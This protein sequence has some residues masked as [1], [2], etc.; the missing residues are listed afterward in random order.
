MTGEEMV[1][2]GGVQFSSVHARI[3]QVATP[4]K[5]TTPNA[6]ALFRHYYAT[7]QAFHTREHSTTQRTSENQVSSDTGTIIDL[8]PPS[9]DRLRQACLEP[10]IVRIRQLIGT[11][12]D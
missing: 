7:T 2:S 8:L 11:S 5:Q 1:G 3:G 12:K 6:T 9:G 4:E 10:N